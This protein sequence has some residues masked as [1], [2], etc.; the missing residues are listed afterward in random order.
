MKV[1]F[2]TLVAKLA[3]SL[4]RYDAGETLGN[5]EGRAMCEQADKDAGVIEDQT[6]ASGHDVTDLINAAYK[7][8]YGMT[9]DEMSLSATA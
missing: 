4:I 6:K 9:A 2:D 3:D 5:R 1:S 7:L 8:V